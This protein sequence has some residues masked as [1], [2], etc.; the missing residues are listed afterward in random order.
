M[1]VKMG[2]RLVKLQQKLK[3][4]FLTDGERKGYI[5]KIEEIAGGTS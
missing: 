4:H 3:R 5:E 1:L 2:Q